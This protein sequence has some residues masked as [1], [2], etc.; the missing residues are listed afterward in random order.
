M[1]VFHWI[2]PVYGLFYG[3]QKRRYQ[4]V[5][6][7]MRTELETAPH[8][9]ILDVGCGTG[10][11]CSVL[12][13][14]GFKVTGVDAVQRML[15][16]AARKPENEAI[17]FKLA[18]ALSGL[19]FGDRGFDFSIASFV[20]HGLLAQERKTLYA[21]MGR[22]TRNLVIIYDYNQ[23]RSIPT[24]IIECLEGGDYFNFIKQA[25]GELAESFRDVRIIDVGKRA[26]WYIC[27]PKGNGQTK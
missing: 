6:G 2:A 14:N 1:G 8:A 15:G 13:Q 27:E 4:T 16:I 5:L 23:N 10:A 24:S 26:A 19:P 17:D 11:M 25:E 9:S 20:A 12:N 3:R 22:V 18:N 21:E 7:M